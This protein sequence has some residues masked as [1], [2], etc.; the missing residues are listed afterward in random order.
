MNTRSHKPPINAADRKRREDAVNYGRASV[1]LEGFKL[2]PADEA[3]AG[4]FINGEIDLAA[5][6]K[7]RNG[8][9]DE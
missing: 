2:S 6:V 5:F 3:H 8:L 1:G 7:S 9:V 4:R